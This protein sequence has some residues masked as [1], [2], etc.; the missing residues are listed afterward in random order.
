MLLAVFC[1]VKMY[2][3]LLKLGGDDGFRVPAPWSPEKSGP[4]PV[5]P[6]VRPI[7]KYLCAALGI[8]DLLFLLQ[9][10]GALALY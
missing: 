3:W 5:T 4:M 2:R 8:F 9:L 1:N 6:A 10:L 7:P